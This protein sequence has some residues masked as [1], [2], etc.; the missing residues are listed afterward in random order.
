MAHEATGPDDL[1]FADGGAIERWV[2]AF[3]ER[4]EAEYGHRRAA[5]EPEITG[6]RLVCAAPTER[7]AVSAGDRAESSRPTPRTTRRANLGRGFAE[8]AIYAGPDL[9]PGAV[10][11]APAIIEETFTTIVVYPGWRARV[12]D[13]GDYVLT[14]A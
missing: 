10:V 8:T 7:P 1:G 11:E 14:R 2:E 6:V 9:A 3:H 13:G 5:E 4:H 12:D